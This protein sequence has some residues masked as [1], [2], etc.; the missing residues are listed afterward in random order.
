MA[1]NN[2]PAEV[3]FYGEIRHVNAPDGRKISH[4][5]NLKLWPDRQS[6]AL[7]PISH[8]LYPL[9]WMELDNEP[10]ASFAWR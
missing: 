8:E 1:V 5:Y 9:I 4:W 3:K 7:T 2:L 10:I 6:V